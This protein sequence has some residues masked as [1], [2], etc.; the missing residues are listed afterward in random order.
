MCV[1]YSTVYVR[2][3]HGIVAVNVLFPVEG[4]ETSE[5]VPAP[6]WAPWGARGLAHVGVREWVPGGVPGSVP[7]PVRGSAHEGA[8]GWVPEEEGEWVHV[9]VPEMAPSP[10]YIHNCEWFK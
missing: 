1:H 10:T 4:W 8:L 2:V 5:P 3:N 6:E 7:S 9:E